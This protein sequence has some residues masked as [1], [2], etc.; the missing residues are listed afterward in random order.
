MGRR[1]CPRRQG[2]CR[3]VQQGRCRLWVRRLQQMNHIYTR[4]GQMMWEGMA[5]KSW[6]ELMQQWGVP[7]VEPLQ[8][9]KSIA[10]SLR[11]I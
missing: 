2:W 4:K 3:L 11:E 10:T 6:T 5:G 8:L 9:Q 7:V 1:M